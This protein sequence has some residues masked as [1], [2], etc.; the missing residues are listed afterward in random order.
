M[1]FAGLAVLVNLAGVVVGAEVVVA[2]GALGQQIADDDENGAGDGTRA[3][4]LP[5]RRARA[6]A[7]AEEGVGDQAAAPAHGGQQR[8]MLVRRDRPTM[9]LPGQV[10]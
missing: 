10:G 4:S 6:V 7:L 1:W 5:R 8:L 9:T 2:V 3:L